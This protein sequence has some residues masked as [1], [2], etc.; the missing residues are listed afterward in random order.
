[1]SRGKRRFPVPPG[2]LRE[3]LD[4]ERNGGAVQP[5]GGENPPETRLKGPPHLSVRRPED[6]YTVSYDIFAQE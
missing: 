1:M 6:D 5:D 4:P 3:S 2:C